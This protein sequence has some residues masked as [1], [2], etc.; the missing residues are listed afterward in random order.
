[1]NHQSNDV[2]Q[3]VAVISHFWAKNQTDQLLPEDLLK[4][5]L[6]MLVNGT[7]EK[8]SS[9]RSFSESALVS[10][11]HLRNNDKKNSQ[12]CL[13][14]LPSGARYIDYNLISRKIISEN[15]IIMMQFHEKI[16]S[17]YNF[18]RCITRCHD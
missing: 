7:K 2:K 12:Q 8:N 10:V 1:M 6:P 16:F 3:M 18:Q 9:V 4:V 11:L 17:F 14:I 15:S 13:Q 5:L